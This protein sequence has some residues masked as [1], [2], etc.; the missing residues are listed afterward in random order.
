[1]HV[2]RLQVMLDV[3]TVADRVHIHEDGD[4][5]HEEDHWQ[6]PLGDS[7]SSI[8]PPEERDRGRGRDNHDL[9]NVICGRDARGR[10]EN[11]H[12]ER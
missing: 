1:M 10:I 5:V 12:Q 2:K 6:S 7:T 4:W 9:S 3:A 11:W 8:S